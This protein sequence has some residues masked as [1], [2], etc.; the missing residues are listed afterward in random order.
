MVNGMVQVWRIDNFD[1]WHVLS[2]AL[3]WVAFL[4]YPLLLLCNAPVACDVV[5][6][7]STSAAF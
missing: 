4:F 2:G 7:I 5:Q 6:Q 3:L 1:R